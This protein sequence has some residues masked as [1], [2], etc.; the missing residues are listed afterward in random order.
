VIMSLSLVM[1][2]G[3]RRLKSSKLRQW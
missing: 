3:R 2:L 1:E